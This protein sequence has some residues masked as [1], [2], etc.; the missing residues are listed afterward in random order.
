MA[1]VRPHA[2]VPLKDKIS[3]IGELRKKFKDTGGFFGRCPYSA[4][5]AEAQNIPAVESEFKLSRA[6]LSPK[7]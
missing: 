3:L 7:P 2:S 1:L 6:P 4:L 5:S